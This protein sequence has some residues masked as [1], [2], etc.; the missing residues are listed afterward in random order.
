MKEKDAYHRLW[1][2]D[3][4]A[5]PYLEWLARGDE[6]SVTSEPFLLSVVDVMLSG[7]TEHYELA[8][9][10][11]EMTKNDFY[12]SDELQL[13]L[14]VTKQQLSTFKPDV[15]T[16]VIIFSEWS[17]ITIRNLLGTIYN[18]EPDFF[19]NIQHQEWMAHQW[20]SG[21]MTDTGSL[22]WAAAYQAFNYATG[23]AVRHLKFENGFMAAVLQD[24][25]SDA[26]GKKNIG[27]F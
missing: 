25:T 4:A 12:L 15:A 9:P 13:W 26:L 17:D 19:A 8:S 6:G 10:T 11:S 14:K 18:I 2:G 24:A 1:A 3:N 22:R 7:D 23:P 20:S 5:A 21:R 16:R 27:T